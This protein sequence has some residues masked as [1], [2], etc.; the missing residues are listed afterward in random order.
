MIYFALYNVDFL[1][2][3]FIVMD[4]QIKILNYEI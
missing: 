4:S 2:R 3:P 1:D